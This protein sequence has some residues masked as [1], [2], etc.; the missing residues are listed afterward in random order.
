MTRLLQA[1]DGEGTAM[2]LGTGTGLSVREILNA[3]ET[4]TGRSMPFTIGPRRAGD[5]PSLVAD[6][7]RALKLLG[8]KPSHSGVEAIIRDAWNWYL[9]DQA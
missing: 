3:I 5:P 2:N 6:S 7:S 4:V 9:K 8:W 1:G